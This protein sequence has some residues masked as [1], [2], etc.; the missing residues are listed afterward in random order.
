MRK[1]RQKTI[2]IFTSEDV[3]KSGNY[4]VVKFIR[5]ADVDRIRFARLLNTN[6]ANYYFGIV[7]FNNTNKIAPAVHLSCGVHRK[8]G[9]TT[10]NSFY[11]EI[12]AFIAIGKTAML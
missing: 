6:I 3:L 9:I 7:S 1:K 2:T 10:I 4:I 5:L 8:P 11:V 12:R